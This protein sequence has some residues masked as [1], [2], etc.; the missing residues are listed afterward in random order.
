MNIIISLTTIP[1][2]LYEHQGNSTTKLALD[3][4]LQQ[5]TNFTYEIH[6][7]IPKKYNNEI[8]IIPEWLS[9]YTSRYSH[10]KIFLTED[11]GPITKL[12]PTLY[13]TINNDSLIILV[14][15]D[16]YYMDGLIDY[17]INGH[18]KYPNSA[19]GFAGITAVDN[20]CHFC[21]TVKNDIR[22]KILEGYKT[23]SYRNSYFDIEEFINNFANKTWNDDISLSAYMGYKNIPKIVLAYEHDKDYSPRVESFPVIGHVPA[24]SSGCRVFRSLPEQ[25][26]QNDM[27]ANEWYRLGYLER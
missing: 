4:I 26:N 6:I 19:I 23:V 2:R 17:H 14:D 21:T 16:L 3:T 10:L 22:V 1:I 25:V 8:I 15:D 12:I 5:K 13:R 18:M 27:I 24:E 7:N 11:Y 20:S 9:S